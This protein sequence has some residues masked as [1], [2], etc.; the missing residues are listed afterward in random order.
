MRRVNMKKNIV[1]LAVLGVAFTFTAAAGGN[2]EEIV[3]RSA[4]GAPRITVEIEEGPS[5]L[6]RLKVLP[7]I[8]V[9]SPPQIAV[10]LETESGEFL[11]TLYVT[12]RA[13]TNSWRSAP[14]DGTPAE[15]ITRPEALPVWSHRAG[16]RGETGAETEAD[17][18]SS[19]TPKGSYSVESDLPE[20]SGR[21]R[22]LLE[23][24][25]STDFNAS[26][27]EDVAPGVTGYSGGLWG[28]G[29]PSL[30]YGVSLATEKNGDTLELELLGHGS[31]AGEDGTVYPDLA[32]LTS[33]LRILDGVHVRLGS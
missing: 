18:V 9:K 28:S 16:R 17:A 3:G 29:Q 32:G 21:V 8:R 25:H 4:D 26:Y 19:A 15:E 2:Q 22:V 14:L 12:S 13:G 20:Q 1:L 5:Y 23:V 7:L 31:P 30:I 10:W 27:P 24:N 6:H 33:A 11:E